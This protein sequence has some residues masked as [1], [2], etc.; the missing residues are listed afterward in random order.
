M[1]PPG[2]EALATRGHGDVFSNGLIVTIVLGGYLPNYRYN[3]S[4]ESKS[5]KTSIS[6]TIFVKISSEN[7]E[8]CH[9]EVMENLYC[10]NFDSIS[11]TDLR[12]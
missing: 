6:K 8:L 7:F 10:V 11:G 2:P 9:I 3:I 12:F 5:G 1:P 4:H